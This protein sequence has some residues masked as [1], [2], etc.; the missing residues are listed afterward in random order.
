M[1]SNK[2]SAPA[3]DEV[4]DLNLNA[5]K[6]ESKGARPFRF[7]WGPD[8]KRFEMQH[9]ELLNQIPLLEA[10]VRGGEA[11][12]TLVTFQ[13]ALGE[14]WKEFRKIPLPEAHSTALME[15]YAKHCGV[16]LGE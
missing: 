15:A 14:Q 8:N 10:A 12:A 11:E 3:D 13:E 7:L 4:F 2:P 1:G 16:D 5:V 6:V 9:S